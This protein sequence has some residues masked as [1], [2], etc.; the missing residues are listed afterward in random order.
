M[1]KLAQLL[2]LFGRRTGPLVGVAPR[3]DLNRI[4]AA[5]QYGCMGLPRELVD[6]ITSMLRD[7]FRALTACSLT[8]KA[9]FASTRPFIHAT[10][11]LTQRNNESILTLR[12]R[13][14]LRRK[15]GHREIRFLSYM[16]E[17]GF[18]RYTRHVE[19]RDPTLTPDN[20]LSHLHH[21]KSLNQIHTLTFCFYDA[22]KWATH[23][24]TC[25]T[26][27]YSTLT[28]LALI[29]PSGPYR[30]LMQFAL[31]FP[32]LENLSIEWSRVTEM[33][34]WPC[35][36]VQLAGLGGPRLLAPVRLQLPIG[37]TRRLLGE[38]C[39]ANTTIVCT[40]P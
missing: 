6:Y 22:V 15:S 19:I 3:V 34:G 18:F 29:C 23:Y 21:L 17:H 9:M 14:Q 37:R 20:I 7:D 24:K 39:S 12:E 30:A 27:F 4:C 11:R 28:S 26:H 31:Q 40:Y 25:F 33:V 38:S 32:K 8:C 10:L 16:G 35:Y 5:I 13:N 2:R 36:H 1:A